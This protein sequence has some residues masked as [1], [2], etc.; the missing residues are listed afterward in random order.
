MASSGRDGAAAG[1]EGAKEAGAGHGGSATTPLGRGGSDD[2]ST[3]GSD[4]AVP[5]GWITT[6]A[7]V[8]AGLG[9]L[10]FLSVSALLGYRFHVIRVEREYAKAAAAAAAVA[11]GAGSSVA[12]GA[13]AG[14]PPAAAQALA[15][16]LAGRALLWGTVGAVTGCTALAAGAAWYF[17][18]Y[19]VRWRCCGPHSWYAATTPT[20]THTRP[21]MRAAVSRLCGCHAAGNA[22]RPRLTRGCYPCTGALLLLLC[23]LCDCT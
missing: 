15:R 6:V 10:A 18:A 1:R 19:S 4:E 20:H 14:R 11:A 9:G 16:Q 7:P 13:A 23:L 17:D 21:S 2:G 8:A 22:A 12:G 3:S 5:T